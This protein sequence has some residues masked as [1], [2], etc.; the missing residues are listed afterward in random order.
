MPLQSLP[1]SRMLIVVLAIVFGSVALDQITKAIVVSH[2]TLHQEVPFLPGFMRFYYT[3]NSGAA[4]SMLSEHPWV[5][6]VFSVIA[7]AVIVYL[8]FRFYRRH[9]LLAVSLAMVLGGGIGNMIDRVLNGYVVDFLDFQ[10]V[11]FAVFNVADIFVTCGSIALAVYIIAV[12]PRLEKRKK[13]A[14][15]DPA[16]DGNHPDQT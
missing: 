12:E 11:H 14:A 8:L 5:F 16:H 7:M 3:E 10:F 4:F 2:M 1:E 15:E 9:P 6:M 13:D